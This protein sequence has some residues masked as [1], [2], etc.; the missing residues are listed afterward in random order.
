MTVSRAEMVALFPTGGAIPEELQIGRSA[1][2]SDITAAAI[3]GSTLIFAEARR[4]GKS[5][6][7]L[8]MTDRILNGSRNRTALSVD[9]R[10]GM[11]SS[12]SL[13][14]VLLKQADKQ[15]AGA[16]IKGMVTKGKLVKLTPKASKGLVAAATLLDE[17]DELAAISSLERLLTPS[18]PYLRDALLALDAHGRAVGERTII[19]LDE[20]QE[21]TRWPD[22][23]EVQREIAATIKRPGSTV[24]F[25][26]SGS[27]KSTLLGLYED[28]KGPLHGLGQR[29]H[30]PDISRDDWCSG[31]RE[32]FTQ[33]GLAIGP[34]QLH[35]IV[36]HS[37]SHPLR[38]MLICAHTLDW[39]TNAE[40][41][42]ESVSR[43]VEAAERHPSWSLT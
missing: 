40:I 33:C 34:E 18:V 13:A 4:L 36:Y 28:P 16:R 5:S 29:F 12:A 9:L 31:L 15:G 17:Q 8:A 43:A 1:A 30:L 3:G 11:D 38:T 21:L 23:D 25:V 10:D 14:G 32:R 19:V 26:F 7:L 35:Q 24:N 2:I 6:L 39:L 20:A 42:V 22:A 41:R 37:D 27:E